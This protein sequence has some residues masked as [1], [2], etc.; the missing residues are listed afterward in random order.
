MPDSWGITDGAV[1]HISGR[2]YNTKRVDLFKRWYCRG[3][4]AGS[5]EY[6]STNRMKKR[7]EEM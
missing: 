2:R 3:Y 1:C 7:R 4:V 5:D 6:Q